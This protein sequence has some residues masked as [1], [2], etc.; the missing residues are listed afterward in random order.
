MVCNNKKFFCFRLCFTFCIILSSI[1]LTI[2]NSAE[3]QEIDKLIEGAKQEGVIN[4]YVAM[5]IKD[6]TRVVN[7]FQKKYPFIKV[8]IFRLSGE[9]LLLRALAEARAGKLNADIFDASIVQISQMK[10]RGLLMKQKDRNR[11]LEISLNLCL[12]KLR[13]FVGFKERLEGLMVVSLRF[14]PEY[15]L[16]MKRM[17]LMF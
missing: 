2:I 12:G 4:Y 15:C 5:S 13:A 16:R 9:K 8:K 3:A 10:K 6:A 14:I 1:L 7:A 17:F 11:R